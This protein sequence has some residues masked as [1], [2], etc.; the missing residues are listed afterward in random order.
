MPEAPLHDASTIAAEVHGRGPTVLLPVN[1]LPA[2]G[3]RAEEPRRAKIEALGWLVWVL[4]GLDHA[5]AMQ[6]VHVLPILRPGCSA[7]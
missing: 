3:A 5:Q 2:E 1:P 6:A 7:A 4:D